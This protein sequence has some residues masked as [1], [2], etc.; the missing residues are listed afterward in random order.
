MPNRWEKP[1]HFTITSHF[2]VQ[3]LCLSAFVF[4][5]PIPFRA[6]VAALHWISGVLSPG[7][8]KGTT[9]SLAIKTKPLRGGYASPD[10]KTLGGIPFEAGEDAGHKRVYAMT[11][12]LKFQRLQVASAVDAPAIQAA[13]VIDY[14]AIEREVQEVY[15]EIFAM[16]TI[17]K[18]NRALNSWY[19]YLKATCTEHSLC[20]ECVRERRP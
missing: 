3:K 7:F 18:Q 14:D 15:R 11:K 9:K 8:F 20:I 1:Q 6:T 2:L 19:S 17:E 13:A 5:P 16:D 12:I 4:R 10:S